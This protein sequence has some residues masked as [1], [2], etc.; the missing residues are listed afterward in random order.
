M[1]PLRRPNSLALL[2]SL[3][4]LLAA[5]PA[6]A[7][8]DCPALPRRTP[9]PAEA[10]PTATTFVPG[11]QTQVDALDAA[12]PSLALPTRQLVFLGDSLTASW[13]PGVFSLFYGARSPLLLGIAG[14]TTQGLLSRLPREWGPL[15]PRVA[16][17]L[18]GTN[19][20]KYGASRPADVALGIAEIVR[21]IHA[22]SPQTRVVLL[23]LLPTGREPTDPLRALDAQV[24]AQIA[25]CADGRTTFYANPGAYLLNAAG[26]LPEQVSFDALHLTPVGYAILATALAPTLTSVLPP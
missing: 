11:W 1:T 2:S 8:G 4:L 21:L 26:Q 10:I 7:Q 18:I 23:G 19:N 5:A 15:R 22:R 25:A 17:L 20:T 13:D 6:H 14:D 9:M 12:L 3:A 24:N 16:V